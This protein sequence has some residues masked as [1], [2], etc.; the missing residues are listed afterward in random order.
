MK[1]KN[2]GTMLNYIKQHILSKGTE[3]LEADD[4]TIN[5]F[6]DELTFTINNI[7]N[8]F[9]FTFFK[10]KQ[11]ITVYKPRGFTEDDRMD[12]DEI[13]Q[14]GKIAEILKDNKDVMTKFLE[15]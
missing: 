14:A 1:F 12:P 13:I 8:G 10:T 11:E 3:D 6:E 7:Y 2:F 9:E 5:I 15:L 4:L